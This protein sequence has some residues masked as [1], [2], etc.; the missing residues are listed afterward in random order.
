MTGSFAEYVEQIAQARPLCRCTYKGRWLLVASPPF[1]NR[2]SYRR[3]LTDDSI[4]LSD[5]GEG[6]LIETAT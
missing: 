2:A 4:R 6:N 3:I 5:T 1:R